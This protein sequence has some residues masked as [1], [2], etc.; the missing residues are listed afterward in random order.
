MSLIFH[1]LYLSQLFLILY[2]TKR[3]TQGMDEFSCDGHFIIS[4]ACDNSSIHWGC[5]LELHPWI[6]VGAA[7]VIL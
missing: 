7:G 5:N 4:N 3:K 6:S 1:L 2:N